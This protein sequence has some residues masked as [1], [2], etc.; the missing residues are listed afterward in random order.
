MNRVWKIPLLV[1]IKR[2]KERKTMTVQDRM[3]KNKMSLLKLAEYLQN[4]RKTCKIHGVSRQ[5]FYEIKQA[6]E[7]HGL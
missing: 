7:E 6:Y 1:T 4:V 5:H 2:K 3:V